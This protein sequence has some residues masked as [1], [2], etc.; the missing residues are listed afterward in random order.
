[1]FATFPGCDIRQPDAVLHH[2]QVSA[3]AACCG[4]TI[5]PETERDPQRSRDGTDVAHSVDTL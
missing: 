3:A 2:L 1:M 5:G 4:C